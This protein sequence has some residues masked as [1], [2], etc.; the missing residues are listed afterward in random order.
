MSV[1]SIAEAKTQLSRL[2]DRAMGGETITITRHGHPVAEIKPVAKA[3]APMTKADLDWLRSRRLTR[4][5]PGLD[6]GVFVSEMR[7]E[8]DERLLRH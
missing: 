2:I 4:K 1:H 5:I 7:D 6:A 3:A 8:D